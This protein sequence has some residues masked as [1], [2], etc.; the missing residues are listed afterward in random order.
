VP[1]WLPRFPLGAEG[2]QGSILL[3]G[4][5]AFPGAHHAPPLAPRLCITQGLKSPF[6]LKEKCDIGSIPERP[7]DSERW[8]IQ[9]RDERE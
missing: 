8:P 1:P 3:P 2:A 7:Q 9:D 4:L 5:D 6:N